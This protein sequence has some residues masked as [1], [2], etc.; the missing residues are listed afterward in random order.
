M[1]QRYNVYTKRLPPTRYR[2]DFTMGPR[3]G[4]DQALVELRQHLSDVIVMENKAKTAESRSR[5]LS[6]LVPG[7]YARVGIWPNTLYHQTVLIY[8]RNDLAQR[9]EDTPLG[10]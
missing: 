3:P 2:G 7:R 5:V 1:R 6:E 9:L 8:A 10:G 4:E